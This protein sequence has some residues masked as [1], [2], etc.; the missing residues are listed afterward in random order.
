MNKQNS[1]IGCGYIP[2]NAQAVC[3]KTKANAR[4]GEVEYKIINEPYERIFERGEIFSM[5]PRSQKHMAV[6]VLDKNTGLT[7]A[8]E[9]E[10]ANLVRIASE[11]KTDKPRE[12]V[13]FIDRAQQIAEELAGIFSAGGGISDK[14]GVVFFT[15]S[16]NGDGKTDSTASFVGGRA[17]RI[18][19]SIAAACSKNSKV[20][21]LVKCGVAEVMPRRMFGG[22]GKKE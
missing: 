18:C 13:E 9:Y 6:N 8:V 11:P 16:D 5:M 2:R 19:E 20:R 15:I 12:K 14:C 4:L 10:P 22:D 17:D 1:I 3:L 21:E 7:Y